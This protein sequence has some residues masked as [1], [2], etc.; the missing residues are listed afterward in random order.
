MSEKL[1]RDLISLIEAG[2]R[3]SN[4]RNRLFVRATWLYASTPDAVIKYV[5]DILSRNGQA[6]IWNWAAEAASR[7]FTGVGYYRFL[8]SAIA[9]YSRRTDVNQP[10]PIQSARAVCRVLMFR[11]DGYKGLDPDLAELF[12]KLALKRLHEETNTGKYDRLFFQLVLL[13]FYLLRFRKA[14]SDAFAP[15]TEEGI[16][17]SVKVIECLQ[18]AHQHFHA[19]RQTGK[20]VRA[21]KI[22]DGFKRYWHYEGGEDVITIIGDFAGDMF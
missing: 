22:I 8:F 15:D 1:E 19:K 13:I 9:R 4:L 2:N 21:K 12:T 17:I 6:K 16:P 10:F 20:A 18:E 14:D 3:T 11:Q 5:E 7:A